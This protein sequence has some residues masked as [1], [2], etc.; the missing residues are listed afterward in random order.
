[1]RLLDAA[2][3]LAEREA[4][5]Q[6]DVE[7]S[8]FYHELSTL[9]PKNQSR[10]RQRSRS[11]EPQR[12][13]WC[14]AGGSSCRCGR[15]LA[16]RDEIMQVWTWPCA[17]GGAHAG[18]DVAYRR[19][20]SYR[21]AHPLGFGLPAEKGPHAEC[22][23]SE[24]PAGV[25]GDG[26]GC[27]CLQYPHKGVMIRLTA[28]ASLPRGTQGNGF[29]QQCGRP[30]RPRVVP[31]PTTDGRQKSARAGAAVGA[32]GKGRGGSRAAAGAALRA[33]HQGGSAQ[34]AAGMGAAGVGCRCERVWDWQRLCVLPFEL[35]FWDVCVH[36]WMDGDELGTSA[37]LGLGLKLALGL[38]PRV[39]CIGGLGGSA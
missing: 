9:H 33:R 19:G 36:V 22:V 21:L 4:T 30:Y 7:R 15:G 37:D 2:A 18:A 23:S 35:S 38:G 26:S 6:R 8:Q 29:P 24:N 1:M 27:D 39:F 13:T 25:R 12:R 17:G 31:L 32:A 5:L 34:R 10:R 20:R 14:R 11:C 28:G 3:E 16:Q